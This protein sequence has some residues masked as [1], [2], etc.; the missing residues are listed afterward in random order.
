MALS[1][2]SAA[3][4]KRRTNSR[5]RPIRPISDISPISPR[6]SSSVCDGSFDCGRCDDF[7]N[8]GLNFNC[9]QSCGLCPLCALFYIKPGCDYCKQGTNSCKRNCKD[10]IVKCDQCC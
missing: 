4:V 9:D 10:G 3:L 2:T 5:I 1:F 7:G 8:D 6:Q